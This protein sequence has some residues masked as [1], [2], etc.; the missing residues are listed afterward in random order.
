[1]SREISIQ[2]HGGRYRAYLITSNNP[3]KHYS[4]WCRLDPKNADEEDFSKACERAIEIFVSGDSRHQD[5]D[6]EKNG[7]ACVFE[8][9]DNGTPHMHMLVSSQSPIRFEVLRSKFPHSEIEPLRG[10]IDQALDYIYKRGEHASKAGTARC[11][12]VTFGRCFMDNRGVALGGNQV[13]DAV[14][15]CLQDGMTPQQIYAMSPTMAFYAGAIERTYSARRCADIPLF[16]ETAV[17]YHVGE[18]GTGKTHVYLDLC[19]E[20]GGQG[21][22]YLVSGDYKHP[23]DSYDMQPVLF[24]DELRGGMLATS[25]LLG[26]CDGYRLTLPA[27]FSNKQKAWRRVVIASVVAPEELFCGSAAERDTFAQFKR[28]LTTVT[29]HFLNKAYPEGD[30]RRYD[31]VSVAGSDYEGI[32]DLERISKKA[33]YGEAGADGRL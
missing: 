4:E 8:V 17:E 26:I 10:T 16:T 32:G 31:S 3:Q 6:P 18:S 13:M 12:P 29:Y 5:R 24:L 20:E 19:E 11:R 1:M 7:A 2:R 25:M 28:R 15:R 14:E 22:V 9:G 21:E 30:S 27:R 33:L 23:W